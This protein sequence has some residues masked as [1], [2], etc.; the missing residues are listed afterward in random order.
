MRASA[1]LGASHLR[2]L[3][4]QVEEH[5]Q[6]VR[7]Q[8][9]EAAA[10]GLCGIEH[11]GA[12]PGWVARRPRPVDPD[13]DVR[14]RAKAPCGEQLAGA[15]REGRVALRQR[16]GDERIKPCRLGSYR[17][18][19]GRVDPHRLF[20]EEGIALIEQVV[21]DA[22]HLPVSP[23]RQHEV[24][25]GRRQHLSVVRE[26]WWAPHL[27]RSFRDETGVRVLD[28]DQLHVRHG[29]QVAQV[30]G[31]VERVPVAYLNGCDANGQGRPLRGRALSPAARAILIL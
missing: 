24:R 4:G 6:P 16:D 13:V 20:H 29:D 17:L 3:A 30:G 12:I 23:E 14:Q 27:S 5:V 1:Q 7:A 22:G 2:L 9:P 18:Y 31:V 15:C 21:G 25:T 10:A 8:V 19:L 11:P 26:S 28:G